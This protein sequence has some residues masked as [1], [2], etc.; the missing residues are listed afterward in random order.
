M[1]RSN[2]FECHL[3]PSAYQNTGVDTKSSPAYS[4]GIKSDL[5]RPNINPGN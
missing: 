1:N 5:N 4:F 3:A 2:F